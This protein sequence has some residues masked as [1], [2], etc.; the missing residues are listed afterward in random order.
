CAPCCMTMGAWAPWLAWC[1]D[2][3]VMDEGRLCYCLDLDWSSPD[4]PRIGV[5]L[6]GGRS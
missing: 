4:L 5:R 1:R 3:M 2:Q 6:L